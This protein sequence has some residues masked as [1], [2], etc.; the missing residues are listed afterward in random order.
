M[1][2]QKD[3]TRTKSNPILHNSRAKTEGRRM[4]RK[5]VVYCSLQTKVFQM[6]RFWTYKTRMSNL[7]QNYWEK[8]GPCCY[9]E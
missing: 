3:S 1:P 8:Q 9:L 2:M 7:S 5:A 4:P 6:L